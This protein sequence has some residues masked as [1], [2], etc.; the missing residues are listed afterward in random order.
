LTLAAT[1]DRAEEEDAAVFWAPLTD[2]ASNGLV[3]AAAGGRP[4]LLDGETALRVVD[5][6]LLLARQRPH[7]LHRAWSAF[8]QAVLPYLDAR[9]NSG[10]QSSGCHTALL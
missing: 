3:R 7:E 4:Q 1:E 8:A 9:N 2:F 6:L 10:A 5:A